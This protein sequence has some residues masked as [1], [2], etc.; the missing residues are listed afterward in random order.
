M[1]IAMLSCKLQGTNIAD[2]SG[3]K[4]LEA[5]TLRVARWFIFK[6]KILSLVKFGGPWNGKCC[7][8]L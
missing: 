7:H 3:E 1:M 8:I 4:P 2:P 5:V 6:P